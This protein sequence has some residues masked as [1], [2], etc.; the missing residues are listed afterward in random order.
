MKGNM[1]YI[2]K[3]KN[4]SKRKT[5]YGRECKNAVKNEQRGSGF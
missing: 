1:I 2:Y 4:N 3:W 5:L